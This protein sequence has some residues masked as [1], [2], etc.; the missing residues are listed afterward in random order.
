MI[1]LLKFGLL[2]RLAIW[3]VR[4]HLAC[5]LHIVK[6]LSGIFSLKVF[7]CRFSKIVWLRILTQYYWVWFRSVFLI[8]QFQRALSEANRHGIYWNDHFR[9][10]NR[11]SNCWKKKHFPPG[12]LPA[13]GSRRHYRLTPSKKPPGSGTGANAVSMRNGKARFLNAHWVRWRKIK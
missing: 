1:V 9:L 3:L 4:C 13:L 8:F 11:H 10:R 12:R 5:E 2:P 7:R 6:Y